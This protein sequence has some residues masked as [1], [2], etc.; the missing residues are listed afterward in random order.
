[1]LCRTVLAHRVQAHAIDIISSAST[2]FRRDDLQ[3]GFE[4]DESFY[5]Q[6]EAVVRGKTEIDLAIDPP[7]DLVVEVEHTR[8]AINK[9]ALLA[10]IGVPEVWRY[11][12]QRLW[13]GQLVNKEYK[14]IRSSVVLNGFPVAQ[15]ELTLQAI[16]SASETQL[17]R[18]FMGKL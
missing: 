8:S 5:I 7:P 3:C 10:A 12:G 16:G 14:P 18:Q 13:L 9:L 17:V 2:I 15:A 1:M 6:H 4:A 11:D